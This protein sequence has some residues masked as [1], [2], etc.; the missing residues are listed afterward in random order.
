MH[1]ASGYRPAGA[2]PTGAA[3]RPAT[4]PA[5]RRVVDAPTRAFHWLFALSFVGAYLSADSEHWRALHVALGYTLAGL[6][7]FRVLYGL[8]GPR[9]ARIHAMLRRLGGSRAWLHSLKVAMRDGSVSA[10]DWRRGQNLMMALAVLG[11]LAVAAP[12]TLSGYGVYAEWGELLGGDWL[13]E[14]HEFL[15]ESM[16]AIVLAHVALIAGLSVLRRRN[17]ALPMLTGRVDGAGPDLA[18]RNHGWL[19]VILVLAVMAFLAREW[20]QSPAGLF[21]ASTALQSPAGK[22]H[23]DHD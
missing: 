7:V 4:P 6:L 23:D 20:Q 21:S 19:A 8:V 22:E 10:I 14:L 18:K 9:H 3:T 5:R 1:T 15:G 17:Q 2:A 12:L 16:L 11:L 13:E